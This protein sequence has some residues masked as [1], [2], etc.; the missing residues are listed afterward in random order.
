MFCWLKPQIGLYKAV[1]KTIVK[2]KKN[3][4]LIVL[5]DFILYKAILLVFDCFLPVFGK[6]L[7]VVYNY[8]KTIMTK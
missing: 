4:N 2:V 7:T 8:D 1:K 3:F 6:V 5:L